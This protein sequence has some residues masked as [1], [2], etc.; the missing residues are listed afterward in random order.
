MANQVLGKV[1]YLRQRSRCDSIYSFLLSKF[2][3]LCDRTEKMDSCQPNKFHKT[4]KTHKK[5]RS[6]KKP[7]NAELQI[8]CH[9]FLDGFPTLLNIPL[10]WKHL[11]LVLAQPPKFLPTVAKSKSGEQMAHDGRETDGS[12]LHTLNVNLSPEGEEG[13]SHFHTGCTLL[14]SHTGSFS[15][16]RTKG[17]II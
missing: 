17:S 5:P 10:W 14:G 2:L 4:R 8:Y 13:R 1:G 6:V 16:C 3:M 11:F 15:P 9:R 7:V 12:V